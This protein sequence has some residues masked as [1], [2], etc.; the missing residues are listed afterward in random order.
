[1]HEWIDEQNVN[2]WTNEPLVYNALMEI[3]K[4]SKGQA[5]L[6]LQRRSLSLMIKEKENKLCKAVHAAW[7]KRPSE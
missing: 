3:L 5:G 4:I 7:I 1:M 2:E 6:R